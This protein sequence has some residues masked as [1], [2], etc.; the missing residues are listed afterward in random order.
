MAKCS[1]VQVVGNDSA[2]ESHEWRNKE[3]IKLG[4]LL[5]KFGSEYFIYQ[6]PN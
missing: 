1:K 4:K 2:S 6:P 5:I 3:K